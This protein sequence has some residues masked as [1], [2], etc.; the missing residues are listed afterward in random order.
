MRLKSITLAGFKSFVEPAS[1]CFPDHLNAI[2]GPNGCGKSNVMDAVRWVM[3]ESSAK[4]L[5]AQQMSD[6]IFNG[7]GSRKPAGQASV[8]L[9]FDTSDGLLPGP[10]GGYAELS[11]RRRISRDGENTYFINGNTCRRRDIADVFLGTGLGPG[12]YAIIG[13]G[14]ISRI[15]EARPE[16][17]RAYVEEAAGISRYK[18]RRKDTHTRMRHTRD[19]LLRLQ[20]SLQGLDEQLQHLQAQATDAEQYRLFKQQARDAQQHLLLLRFL[21]VD[22]RWQ[23]QVQAITAEETVM[24]QQQ[25]LQQALEV[26]LASNDAALLQAQAERGRL[27]GLLDEESAR[28]TQRDRAAAL[29]AERSAQQHWQRQQ[30]DEEWQLNQV[31]LGKDQHSCAESQAVLADVQARWQ[32]A[33]G[34]LDQAVSAQSVAFRQWQSEQELLQGLQSKR[35][36]MQAQL[37]ALAAQLEGLRLRPL[38]QGAAAVGETLAASGDDL[39]A[40]QQR[41]KNA[42]QAVLASWASYEALRQKTQGLLLE[43]QRQWSELS[44]AWDDISRAIAASR[45]SEAYECWRAQGEALHLT[46]QALEQSWQ[47]LAAWL[48]EREALLAEQADSARCLAVLEAQQHAQQALVHWHQE[49]AAIP[50]LEAQ[51]H[52]RQAQLGALDAAIQTAAEQLLAAQKAENQAQQQLQQART[53]ERDLQLQSAQAQQQLQQAEQLLARSHAQQERIRQRQAELPDTSLPAPHQDSTLA[54]V[55]VA[56]AASRKALAA[57]EQSVQALDEDKR[58]LLQAHHLAQRQLAQARER[59]ED[60]RLAGQAL[61]TERT[62]TLQQIAQAGFDIDSGLAMLPPQAT[63]EGVEADLAAVAAALEALGPV[64]LAALDEY[65]RLAE[66]QSSLLQQQADLHQA[67]DSLDNAISKIDRETR[68]R[69]K[70][71]FDAINQGLQTLF[72]TVF[73]GGHAYLELTGDDLLDAGV[74]IMARPPGKKNSTIHVLSGGEKAL[75]AIALVFAIFRLNPAPFCLLDEVDAPLDD[76]N[77]GR[78]A[79]LLSAMAEQ[80]QFIYI[81]HN[82]IAMEIAQHLLGVTMHEAGVS[83]VVSVDIAQAAHWAAS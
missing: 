20:D 48:H 14:T 57:Q 37:D 66:R 2:V 67:L 16:E 65:Q 44:S 72:P 7:S 80:V 17:L 39:A 75:T 43:Q 11:I 35:Q 74:T 55:E 62:L 19:N 47:T 4:Q 12:S 77:V 58:R 59:W 79:R 82:K 63:P 31:Q 71:T 76:A 49:L 51:W 24:T 33:C 26:E 36:Q 54:D 46:F 18:E 22:G 69:F 30:L 1:L 28:W 41:C 13:Q 70:E 15:I 56:L 5:R 73:G 8:E 10:Y 21:D 40:L 61:A 68:A 52:E 60:C 45:Q 64:N 25:Q 27:Q 23:E 50:Q 83:R 38:G 42:D 32:T 9:V 81:T 34:A 53:Q 29:A 3:G 78:F 6:V